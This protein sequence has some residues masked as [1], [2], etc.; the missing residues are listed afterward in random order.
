LERTR[1]LALALASAIGDPGAQD[2][3]ANLFLQSQTVAGSPYVDVADLCLNLMRASSD[4]RVVEAA[5]A[6]GDFL[7]D[8]QV[9]SDSPLAGTRGTKRPFVMEHGRTTC[10]TA[11]LN[12]I[13]IYA[14]HV[15]LNTDAANARALYQNFVFTEKTLWSELVHVL[16][17]LG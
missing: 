1:D 3:I 12:G 6:L 15:A 17:G 11:R 5:T 2:R 13:S 9:T 8:P 16:A 7:I 14:P 10:E 4:S